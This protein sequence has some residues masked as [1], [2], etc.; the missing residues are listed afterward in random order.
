[1]IVLWL[2]S[3][4]SQY[5][6]NLDSSLNNIFSNGGSHKV[7]LLFPLSCCFVFLWLFF[8]YF[9]VGSEQVYHTFPFIPFESWYINDSFDIRHHCSISFLLIVLVLLRNKL[10]L[11]LLAWGCWEYRLL[12]EQEA[13]M[14]KLRICN[15]PFVDSHQ[16]VRI[17]NGPSWVLLLQTCTLYLWKPGGRQAH[18]HWTS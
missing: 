15:K 17:A 13:Q 1:M 6:A 16:T 4:F 18:F 7:T 3:V 10:H 5:S 11:I 9:T 2:A 14:R 12:Y 8:C